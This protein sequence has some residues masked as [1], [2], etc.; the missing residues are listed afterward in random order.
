MK[1]IGLQKGSEEIPLA[2]FELWRKM[3]CKNNGRLSEVSE[4]KN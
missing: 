1:K 2:K 4:D 3:K